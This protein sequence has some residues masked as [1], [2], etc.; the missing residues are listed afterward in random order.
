MSLFYVGTLVTLEELS[1]VIEKAKTPPLILTAAFLVLGLMTRSVRWKLV[2]GRESIKA[3][4]LFHANVI[5]TLC[6]MLLPARLGEVVRM[7]VATAHKDIGATLALASASMDRMIDV[8]VLA[9]LIIGIQF[10][11]SMEAG[12]HVWV[13]FA[14]IALVCLSVMLW[15]ASQGWQLPIKIVRF[16]LE[17]IVGKWADRAEALIEEV[18]RELVRFTELSFGWRLFS[19]IAL[20]VAAD[21][22][23]ISSILLTFDL[24]LRTS[25]PFVLWAGLSA[26][27]ILPAAPGYVGVYQ[28]AA[29]WAL[30]FYGVSAAESVVVA[31]ALQ[32]STLFASA[33]LSA[34]SAVLI[35]RYSRN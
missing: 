27:S 25:M 14:S 4:D 29:V 24:E 12:F 17:N 1:D 23:A 2:T 19:I 3:L 13:V 26:A 6:N 22:A 18:R 34:M 35:Y 33:V 30:S 32:I 16:L 15:S 8:A 20:V 5:G 21:L 28:V 11:F 9:M 7:F 10:F 31:T